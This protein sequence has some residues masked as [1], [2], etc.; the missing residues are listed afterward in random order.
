MSR[1]NKTTHKNSNSTPLNLKKPDTG[2]G[3]W[4]RISDPA[5]TFFKFGRLKKSN[6]GVAMDMKR[7]CLA[8]DNDTITLRDRMLSSIKISGLVI[9][10]FGLAAF[11]GVGYSNMIMN[12][13]IQVE[14]ELLERA[15]DANPNAMAFTLNAMAIGE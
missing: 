11:T 8:N 1:D 13:M 10:C 12:T 14:G 5:A 3:G 6:K 4:K 9:G 2:L 15:M 7:N